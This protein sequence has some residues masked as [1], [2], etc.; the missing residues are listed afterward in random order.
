MEADKENLE[1]FSSALSQS[2]TF[3][4]VL[5]QLGRLPELLK[6]QPNSEPSADDN[7][8]KAPQSPN[9]D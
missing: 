1:Q 9:K 6:Q 8:P 7:R 2:K 5:S 3:G 4:E